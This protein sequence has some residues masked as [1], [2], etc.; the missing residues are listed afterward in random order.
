MFET[1]LLIIGAVLTLGA[2]WGGI[3][4]MPKGNPFGC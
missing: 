1:S 4:P 3:R 2:A